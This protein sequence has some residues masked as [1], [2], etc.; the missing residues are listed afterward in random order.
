MMQAIY[1]SIDE[2]KPF[3]NFRGK[4]TPDDYLKD[5]FGSWLMDNCQKTDF[6]KPRKNWAVIG[7]P[8]FGS[9]QDIIS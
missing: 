7:D 6:N 2:Q 5:M 9:N 3:Y 4:A 1:L 8:K